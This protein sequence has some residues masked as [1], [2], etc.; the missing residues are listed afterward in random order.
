[1]VALAVVETNKS[2]LFNID[3]KEVVLDGGTAC[4]T[5]DYLFVFYI[6]SQHVND[7]TERLGSYLANGSAFFDGMD[8]MMRKSCSVSATSVRRYLPSAA[9]IFN[10]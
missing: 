8:W 3:S 4:G 7:N 5:N 1:M 2:V 6:K 10:W 9:R